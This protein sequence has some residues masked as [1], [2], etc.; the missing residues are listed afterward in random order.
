MDSF[1]LTVIG[2]GPGGYVAAIRAAQLG[3][4]VA[5][6]ER[7]R[8]GGVCLNWGCIPT[9]A[10][11]KIAEQ[12]EFLK[13][14]GDWG[15]QLPKIG[16]EWP[17]VIGRSRAAADKLSKGVSALMKKNKISVLAG[18]GRFLAANR[19][20]VHGPDKVSEVG[21]TRSIIATGARASTI[22]GVTLDGRKIIS[23][24][25]AMVLEELPRSMVIIGAGAIGAEFAYFYAAFGTEVTLLEYFDRILPAGDEEV[26][27]HVERSFK[28]RGMKIHT[29]ARVKEATVTR[30]GATRTVFVKDGAE[31]A[32]EAD[33][34]L[35][36]VGV[37]GNVE[38]LGLEALGIG[39]EK[40]FIKVDDD[41]RTQV[42]GVYA[43]GDVCG[44]PALAHVA[45]AEGVH[46]VEHIAGLNPRP[47]D[48]PSIP[49]CI[50]C[51][52]QVAS[53]GLSEKEA[54][55][56]GFE[57]KVGRFPFT[58][59]GKSVAIGETEGF[60]KIIGDQRHGEI[61][62]AH[63][64]G[65]DATELIAEIALA[66]ATEMTVDDLHHTVHSHP[67]LSESVMEAA[68]DWKGEAVQI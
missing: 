4:K 46:A 51:H 47:V 55:E 35:V 67:T 10:L 57:V 12:H 30:G 40:S 9:K 42:E 50:Y 66:K 60:V 3:M 54:R 39:V 48:Y 58:A 34:V 24:K 11:L 6:V 33:V 62:G 52:P 13:H 43:I 32:V 16:I 26:S 23:S 65:A 8:L 19:L 53:V 49:A 64:F 68:G 15:F 59:N 20:A 28:K 36:A 5:I 37:R 63:I 17:K 27:K 38:D 1:D 45:S 25:E 31:T 2:S 21:T 41:L 7:D 14:A 29:S 44:P 56:Q 22:P 61:L 18:A